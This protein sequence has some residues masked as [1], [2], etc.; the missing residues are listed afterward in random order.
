MSFPA[1][2]VTYHCMYHIVFRKCFN[3]DDV[4]LAKPCR[5]CQTPSFEALTKVPKYLLV[6]PQKLLLDPQQF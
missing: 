4:S 1:V 3:N 2:L 5:I 6:I